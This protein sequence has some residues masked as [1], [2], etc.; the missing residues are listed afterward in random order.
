M[1]H[2]LDRQI[3][4]VLMVFRIAAVLG[5]TVSENPTQLHLVCI[6]ER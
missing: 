1:V 3:E 4:P 2:V 6:E 5:A